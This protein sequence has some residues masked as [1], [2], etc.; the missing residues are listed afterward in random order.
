MVQEIIAV[1]PKKSTFVIIFDAYK[2]TY[3]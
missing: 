3:S 2:V 1:F